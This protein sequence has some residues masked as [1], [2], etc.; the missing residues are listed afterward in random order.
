[1]S[2]EH[3]HVVVAVVWCDLGLE[4]TGEQRFAGLWVLEN[5]LGFD[6][7]DKT[8]F[9]FT[10]SSFNPMMLRVFPPN[11]EHS[12]GTLEVDGEERRMAENNLFMRAGTDRAA[13]ISWAETKFSALVRL[14]TE[15]AN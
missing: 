15:L 4:L 13:I 9:Y 11:S 10:V 5:N 6:R 14:S 1:M 2:I 7:A 3:P 12:I 8:S